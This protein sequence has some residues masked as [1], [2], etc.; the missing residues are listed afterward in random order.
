MKIKNLFATFAIAAVVFATACTKDDKKDDVKTPTVT[1]MSPVNN[2]ED[3]SLNEAITATFSEEMDALTINSSTFIVKKGDDE[4]EGVVTYEGTIATFTPNAKLLIATDYTATI[5][6]GA[7]NIAGIACAANTVWSFATGITVEVLAKVELGSAG[8][9][10]ILAKTAISN[11]PTSVIT[12]DLGL[13]PAATSYITGFDLI[14]GTGFATSAQITGQVFAAD[15]AAPTST[16]LTTAVEN[17][18]TAYNDAAERSFPDYVE[19]GAGNIGGKTLAP[20]LY[21]W[22]STVALP[23]DVTITGSETDIWI[24]QIEGDLIVSSDVKLTL[25]GGAKASNVFWQ[26]AGAVSLGTSS[27]FEGVV[28]SMTSITMKTKA[29]FKG[30][31]LAQTSVILDENTVN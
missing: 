20:G 12:G 15:M 28:M 9:Y 11:S 2:A 22:T 31:A 19:L 18:L 7:K 23:I 10:A 5:T 27:H 24:F 1:S 6:T 17:M 29:S 30:K 26:V 16:V 21:K 25:T 4:I 8:N 3:V 13:S 14:D